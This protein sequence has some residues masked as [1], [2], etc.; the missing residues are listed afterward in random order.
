VVSPGGQPWWSEGRFKISPRAFC[1]VELKGLEPLTPCLQIVA[2][3]G[4]QGT[5]LGEGPPAGIRGVLLLTIV[6]G[7]L[8]ARRPRST[9][10]PWLHAKLVVFGIAHE[11]ERGVAPYDLRAQR[12]QPVDFLGHTGWRT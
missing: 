4:A 6:N 8:M 7:T 5:E 3:A 12:F 1:L 11:G 10:W 9:G 2:S